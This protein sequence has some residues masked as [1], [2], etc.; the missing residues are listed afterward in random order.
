MTNIS[1]AG[2]FGPE[3]TPL[4]IRY[5]PVPP[6]Y[7]VRSEVAATRASAPDSLLAQVGTLTTRAAEYQ[8]TVEAQAHCR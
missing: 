6:E 5:T 4:Q 1:S 7:E 8:A 2:S 3:G